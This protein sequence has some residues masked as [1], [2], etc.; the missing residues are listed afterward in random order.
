MVDVKPLKENPLIFKIYLPDQTM[1][2]TK[3]LVKGKKVY[4]E[5]LITSDG[6]EY[7]T[8]DSKR[9]K[10]ASAILSGLTCDF[11]KEDTR[12]LYLGASTGTTV[13]HVS[14]IV[15]DGIIYAVEYS[16]A[17]LKALIQLA[18][19]RPNIAPILGDARYPGNYAD[20]V[21]EV[22]VV[23]ADV[24]QPTQAELFIKNIDFFLRP[25]GT[26]FIAIKT[27]SISQVKTFDE[28]INEVKQEL[29]NNGLEV[30]ALLDITSFH[31]EHAVIVV[32]N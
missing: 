25:K 12:V 17:S 3:N 19:Q 13:S 23:Y 5:R 14:D 26:G 24:A 11:L 8:W 4:G 29:I 10:L 20:F 9:S 21:S 31:K 1:L 22:D 18:E 16:P 28:I 2:G 30:K 32:E 7:R 15:K 27:K 6:E